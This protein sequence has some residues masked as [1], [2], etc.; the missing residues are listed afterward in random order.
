MNAA[1]NAELCYASAGELAAWIRRGDLTPSVVLEAFLARIA[2]LNPQVN[3]IVTLCADEA[4]A[5]AAQLEK[6]GADAK[7]RP[8]H[9]LPIAIKDLA[10]TRGIR[11]TMGSPIYRDFRQNQ[12]TRIWCGFTDV[13]YVVWRDSQPLRFEQNLRWFQWR[14]GD[15]A[16]QRPVTTGRRQRPGWL[17]AQSSILLQCRWFTPLTGPG[18]V[19]AQTIFQ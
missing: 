15:G 9:G 13:Q 8:L 10:L 16:R 18:T 4:R 17:L 6:L 19:V 7:L 14:G 2:A 12:Y 5:Q 1:T 3:A 11:T